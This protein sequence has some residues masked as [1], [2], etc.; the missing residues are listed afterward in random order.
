MAIGDGFGNLL[1]QVGTTSRPSGVTVVSD[2]LGQALGN[3]GQAIENRVKPIVIEAAADEGARD[4]ADGTPKE[5]LPITDAN[6]AYNRAARLTYRNKTNLDRDAALDELAN[7]FTYDQKG[8]EAA[9][10]QA[11]QDTL[12]KTEPEYSVEIEQGWQRQIQSKSLRIAKASLQNLTQETVASTTA[13]LDN[14]KGRLES[15][16]RNGM[17]G[18]A[19]SKELLAEYQSILNEKVV[20]PIFKYTD[21]QMA[22][23][24]KFM[25][26]NLAAL[27]VGKMVKDTFIKDLEKGEMIYVADANARKSF[28]EMFAKNPDLANMS[29]VDKQKLKNAADN[30]LT[31]ELS[32][33][34]NEEK[35]KREEERK[36]EEE[37]RAKQKD[38]YDAAWGAADSGALSIGEI[39][40]MKARGEID[41]R[42]ERSLI[43][44][45]RAGQN[46]RNAEARQVRAAERS[47]AADER[48]AAAESRRAR[49]DGGRGRYYDLMDLAETD[50]DAAVSMA[51][52]LRSSGGLTEPQL[53]SVTLHARS[54]NNSDDSF[55]KRDLRETMRGLRLPDERA[56]KILD[57]YD[58]WVD[59][60]P[61]ATA[62]QRDAWRDA[63]TARIRANVLSSS[64][65]RSQPRTG[66]PQSI[67]QKR[68]QSNALQNTLVQQRARNGSSNNGR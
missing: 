29:E 35:A 4:G 45:L 42:Y 2:P 46:R 36:V 1:R 7:Q 5:R 55:R 61:Q 39:N 38:T 65:P 62:A 16:A 31:A 6:V 59:A 49:S 24:V 26:G 56:A 43:G 54:E 15:A 63:A 48:R 66:Q 64:P 51:R 21:A 27:S 52:T 60:N 57:S 41:G 34:R 8:F 23:D 37:T 10:A 12:S 22:N 40:A 50:P 33:A 20:N 14:L 32:I 3:L 28:E 67:Q 9:A 30:A 68:Q 18:D 17:M 11:L 13:R 58:R 25:N 44:T 53:R 19:E 47:A